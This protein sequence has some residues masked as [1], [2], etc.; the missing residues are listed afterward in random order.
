MK[1]SASNKIFHLFS[2]FF[3]CCILVP[4]WVNAAEKAE[5]RGLLVPETESVLSSQ[6]AGR[7]TDISVKEG[8][9]FKKDQTLVTFDCS[10]LKAELQKARMKLEAATETHD[11]NL[12][13]MELGSTSELEVALSSARMKGAKAEVLVNEAKTDMCVIKA[14]FSGRVVKRPVQPFESVKGG[15]PLL[16]ILDDLRL[17]VHLLIPSQWLRWLK[18]G[19][20]FTIRIDETGKTYKGKVTMTGARVNPVNQT[21]EVSASI[22]GKNNELLAG[23]SGTAIF[24]LPK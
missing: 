1:L 9:R 4:L 24:T 15:D 19:T 7:I 17:R 5:V 23:M 3:L 11:A 10:I 22:S 21:L 18:Q 20:P 8:D 14:P 16:E 13:L 2:F 6:I 12:Q